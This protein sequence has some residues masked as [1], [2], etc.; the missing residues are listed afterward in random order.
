MTRKV[1]HVE[2]KKE[3]KRKKGGKKG[4]MELGRK[5]EEGKKEKIKHQLLIFADLPTS[6]LGN[7][8]HLRMSKNFS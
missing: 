8:L 6:R 3:R 4:G 7:C 1:S 5:E 2:E